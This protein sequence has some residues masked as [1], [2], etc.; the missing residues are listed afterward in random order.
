M[1]FKNDVYSYKL[2]QQN[3]L[4]YKNYSNIELGLI[5][6]H[7]IENAILVIEAFEIIKDSKIN[8]LELVWYNEMWFVFLS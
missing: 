8:G 2:N 7:Q 6:Y 4:F 3:P 1:T 5:G